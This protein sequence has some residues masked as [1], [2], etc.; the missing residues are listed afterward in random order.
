MRAD[1][2]P[3]PAAEFDRL[4]LLDKKRDSRASVYFVFLCKPG[5]TRIESVGLKPSSA[6]KPVSRGWLAKV[7]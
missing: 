2:A 7:D 4:L 6:R 3:V 5:R 1:S